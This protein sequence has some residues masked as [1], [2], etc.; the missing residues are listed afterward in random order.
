MMTAYLWAVL[1]TSVVE[2]DFA[3]DQTAID[4]I[5]EFK[6][7]CLQSFSFASSHVDL[8]VFENCYDHSVLVGSS[9]DDPDNTSNNIHYLCAVNAYAFEFG[10]M[11]KSKWY[12]HFLHPSV[13]EQTYHLS[14]RDHLRDFR[15]LF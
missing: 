12:K 7:E 2:S 8:D 11:Y 3:F 6:D 4:P 13:Q 9:G 14:S 5:Q 1:L 15:L 10:D